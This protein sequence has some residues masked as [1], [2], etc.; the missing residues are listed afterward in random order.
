MTETTLS[1]GM[2]TS[3]SSVLSGAW[4][5]VVLA[6]LGVVAMITAVLVAWPALAYIASRFF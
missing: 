3:A 2:A 5:V 1:K 6:A 4:V